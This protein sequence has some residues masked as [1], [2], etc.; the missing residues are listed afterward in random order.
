MISAILIAKNTAGGEFYIFIITLMLFT[1]IYSASLLL[2][3]KFRSKKGIT[4]ISLS[5]A[6]AWAVS[7][8]AWLAY[9]FSGGS[10]INRGIAG[11]YAIL[12]FPLLLIPAGIVSWIIVRNE[13]KR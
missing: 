6:A 12:I 13:M 9:Y 2:L 1:V 7:D 5:S 3:K 8:I 10:Y 11:A 4:L